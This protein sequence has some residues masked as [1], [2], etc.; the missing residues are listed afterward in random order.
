M[1]NGD[2][3]SWDGVGS[4]GLAGTLHEPLGQAGTG[5][6]GAGEGEHTSKDA[7]APCIGISGILRF[8][9]FPNR[10]MPITMCASGGKSAW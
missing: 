9:V 1:T 10:W 3:A 7:S 8:Q 5:E 2:L 4:G 6:V